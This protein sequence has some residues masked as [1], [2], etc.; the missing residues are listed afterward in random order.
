MLK[1]E[2]RVNQRHKEEIILA[3]SNILKAARI[4]LFFF[5]LQIHLEYFKHDIGVS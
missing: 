1:R 2:S 5:F 3:L 4:N